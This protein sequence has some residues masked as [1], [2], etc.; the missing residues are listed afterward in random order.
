M[1]ATNGD[2]QVELIGTTDGPE[3]MVSTPTE[4][5]MVMC[6]RDTLK[7]RL[8]IDLRTRQGEII[9]QAHSHLA[10]LEVGGTGWNQ[11][12]LK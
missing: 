10:G 6:C 9:I 8:S 4:Q 7:G 3:T 11:A 12:W 2:V 1:Q 5:G